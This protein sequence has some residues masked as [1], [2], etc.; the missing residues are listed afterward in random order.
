[1]TVLHKAGV[2]YEPQ[3]PGEGE[4]YHLPASASQETPS[5]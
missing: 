5:K 1:M 4:K 2:T 3:F